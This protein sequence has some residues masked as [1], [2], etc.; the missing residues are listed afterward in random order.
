MRYA[1]DV[2]S[3]F[4]HSLINTMHDEHFISNI[5]ITVNLFKF[6]SFL[7]IVSVYFFVC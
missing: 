2:V 5:N 1:Y 4:Y 3:S 7:S 6:G